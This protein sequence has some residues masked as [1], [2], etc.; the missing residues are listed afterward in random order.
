MELN[1]LLF[2]AP[3]IKY[4]AEDLEDELMFIPRFIKYSKNHRLYLKKL[5]KQN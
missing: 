5:N 1:S 4:T 3:T 2:P